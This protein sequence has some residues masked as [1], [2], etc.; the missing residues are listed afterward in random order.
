MIAYDTNLWKSDIDRVLEILPELD[1][2]AGK[3]ILIT[4]A[5]GLICSSVVDILFRYNNDA[6]AACSGL[7]NNMKLFTTRFFSS[8]SLIIVLF[9]ARL[10]LRTYWWQY[11]AMQ[12]GTETDAF[13]SWIEETTMWGYGGDYVWHSYYVRFWNEDGLE[14]EAR[15]LNPGKKLKKGSRV[16]I[17]YIPG[18]EEIAALMEITDLTPEGQPGSRNMDHHV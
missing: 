12:N 6:E 4:G 17:R 5:A 13:V 8:L 15:L 14:T 1:Q 3:S 7:L 16:R 2:M 9:F 11:D 10:V 18:H